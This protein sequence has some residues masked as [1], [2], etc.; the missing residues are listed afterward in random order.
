MSIMLCNQCVM[1]L[2][3]FSE[4]MLKAVSKVPPTWVKA[5]GSFI[6]YAFIEGMLGFRR[7][8]GPNVISLKTG[9]LIG[10]VNYCSVIYSSES[11]CV[12][13]SINKWTPF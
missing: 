2:L 5:E 4:E 8:W 10:K 12:I 3:C 1:E 13:L 6:K 9:T 7:Y 11:M